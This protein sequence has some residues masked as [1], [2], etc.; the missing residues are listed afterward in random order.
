MQCVKVWEKGDGFDR[1]LLDFQEV[2]GS[3]DEED[4]GLELEYHDKA[5]LHMLAKSGDGLEWA[6]TDVYVH[7]NL[8]IRKFLWGKL[9]EVVIIRPW[10]LIGDFNCVLLA[11]ER[12]SNNGASSSF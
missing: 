4:I 5:F 1:R 8:S 2:Y 7:P 12:S 3:W 11:E 6:L 9:S 10:V